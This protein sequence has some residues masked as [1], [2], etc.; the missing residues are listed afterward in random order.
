M[1]SA[2]SDRSNT[3]ETNCEKANSGAPIWREIQKRARQ[4]KLISSQWRRC[5][6]KWCGWCSKSYT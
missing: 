3:L 1:F 2:R 6:V 5:L 4:R